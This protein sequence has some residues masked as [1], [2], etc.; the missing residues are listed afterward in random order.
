MSGVERVRFVSGRALHSNTPKRLGVAVSGGGDSMA[1]LDLMVSHGAEQGFEVFAAT[2][3][4]GLRADA[5]DEIARVRE[6]CAKLG[7]THEVLGWSWDGTG[8]LQAQ[9]RAARYRL[10]ADWGLR[11]DLDCITLGHTEGDQAETVLMRLARKSGVDGLAAMETRFARHNMEWLRPLLRLTRAELRDYLK[12]E[13]ISWCE[14]PSN[15][16]PKFERVR[17]RQ[18]MGVLHDLG[19]PPHSLARVAHQMSGARDALRHY[20]RHEAGWMTTAQGGDVLVHWNGP[21][22]PQRGIVPLEIE[23]R[24][25]TAALSYISGA[26]FGPRSHGLA[27]LQ[28]ELIRSG[29]STLH[30]CLIKDVPADPDLGGRCARI[31]REWAAVKD[32]TG[33]TDQP[34]DGRWHLEGP[35]APDLC[36]RALGEEGLKACPDWRATGLP[37]SSLLASPAIWH[38]GTVIAAPLAGFANGWTATL[39]PSFAEFLDTH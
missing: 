36:I 33:P 18:A 14:D 1:L 6:L 9:A 15:D 21:L 26:E 31:T 4:H 24:I 17:M 23:R 28:G 8:N 32:E 37:R 25:F 34:W 38:E 27:Q 19:I 7:V 2:V 20:T 10:L 29:T 39:R 35:H 13:D 22:H 3:D 5:S 12:H 16:D 11:L 30:G